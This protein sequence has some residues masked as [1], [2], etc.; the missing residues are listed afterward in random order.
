MDSRDLH[1]DW[2]RLQ[3]FQSDFT[4]EYPDATEE[5]DP[6]LP[7]PCGKPLSTAIFCDADHGHDVLTRRS[8][9]GIIV[10]VGR[11][12]V[13]WISRRQGA[14]ATSTYHAEFMALR[15][16]TE[17][18][19]A[20]RYMLRSLGIPVEGPTHLLG[21]N[22]GVIQNAACAD[23]QLKKKHVALSY[24]FVRE[25]TAAKIVNPV[26]IDGS[27]NFSDIC[28]KQVSRNLFRKHCQQLMVTG[29]A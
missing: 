18:A 4:T 28:T 15:T 14:I 5:V 17:E 24:H 6:R 11:T 2:I 13:N 16:A 22:L 21:D 3:S 20:I 12:P 19:I 29:E 7:P 25:A 10:F 23:S 9:T 8:I 27:F 26:K 1:F